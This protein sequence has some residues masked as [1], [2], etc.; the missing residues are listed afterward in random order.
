MDDRELLLSDKLC[1]LFVLA[2]KQSQYD[3]IAFRAHNYQFQETFGKLIEKYQG[4]LPEMI[5]TERGPGKTSP[6]LTEALT[7]LTAGGITSRRDLQ[8]PQLLFLR[9]SAQKYYEECV[10]PLLSEE[11][12]SGLETLASELIKKIE[13]GQGWKRVVTSKI[14]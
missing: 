2:Q 5:F 14:F 7:Y 1:A 6:A 4:T 8:D 10:E 12:I 3:S 13:V 11:E 9:G